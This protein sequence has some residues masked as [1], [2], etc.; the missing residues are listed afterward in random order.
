[1]VPLAPGAGRPDKKPLGSLG[2]SP[3]AGKAAGQ[4]PQ[5]RVH[6]SCRRALLPV[7]APRC[8][9]RPAL[10]PCRAAAV[11]CC[12]DAISCVPTRP[13]RPP[14]NPL[15]GWHALA[16]R[17]RTSRTNR[18]L[19]LAGAPAGPGRL[20]R[21]RP[22]SGST[23]AEAACR[24]GCVEG[25]VGFSG[26]GARRFVV[27]LSPAVAASS[28][29]TATSVRM[30][31]SRWILPDRIPFRAIR[32][33]ADCS[34]PRTGCPGW[35]GASKWQTPLSS[36]SNAKKPAFPTRKGV[37]QFTEKVADPPVP[38]TGRLSRGLLNPGRATP[39]ENK[40][41]GEKAWESA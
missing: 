33:A 7:C 29:P 5:G 36:R 38:A 6:C 24:G 1:M 28:R 25:S 21:R 12:P 4:K 32:S 2:M 22:S 30:S 27:R 3:R 18:T 14:P 8:R 19:T 34:L 13:E 39:A 31:R 37:C 16:G 10:G 9:W 11:L 40:G 15:L 17:Q 41:G 23:S 26:A 35:W 20:A